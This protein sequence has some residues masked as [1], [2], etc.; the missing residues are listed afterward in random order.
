MASALNSRS[1]QRPF[2]TRRAGQHPMAMG[3]GAGTA[4]RFGVVRFGEYHNMRY[5][6]RWRTTRPCDL[7]LVPHTGCWSDR[8]M[9]PRTLTMTQRKRHGQHGSHSIRVQIR[10]QAATP[11]SRRCSTAQ[12]SSRPTHYHWRTIDLARPTPVGRA[13]TNVL[14]RRG[15][16]PLTA[17]RMTRVG[18]AHHHSRSERGLVARLISGR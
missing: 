4:Q 13:S 18:R 1:A 8:P 10:V 6:G 14:F 3:S 17:A 7:E 12:G 2:R 11:V 15:G 16:L 9:R 5:G